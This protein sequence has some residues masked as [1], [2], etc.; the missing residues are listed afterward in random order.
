MEKYNAYTFHSDNIEDKKEKQII[1]INNSSPF[2]LRLVDVVVKHLQENNEELYE[3]LKNV[4]LSVGY[5]ENK[6]LQMGMILE[7][8]FLGKPEQSLN[9]LQEI[10]KL[11]TKE[12]NKISLEKLFELISYR[13]INKLCTENKDNILQH[14]LGNICTISRIKLKSPPLMR[15]INYLTEDLKGFEKKHGKKIVKIRPIKEEELILNYQFKSKIWKIKK[16]N[17]LREGYAMVYPDCNDNNAI[18]IMDHRINFYVFESRENQFLKHGFIPEIIPL[19]RQPPELEKAQRNDLFFIALLVRVLNECQKN[20]EIK[21]VFVPLLQS[22]NNKVLINYH[23]F[24]IEK[25]TRKEA[26]APFTINNRKYVRLARNPENKSFFTLYPS[27]NDFEVINERELKFLDLNNQL[28]ILRN[29]PRPGRYCGNDK[30][31][32]SRGYGPMG[33][34]FTLPDEKDKFCDNHKNWPFYKVANE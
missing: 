13:F 18:L 29:E 23:N 14:N 6:I 33:R 26:S 30:F 8:Y 17:I 25:R 22:T 32:R 3:K 12:G 5:V 10:N 11:L 28:Q 31:Y 4:A 9:L 27:N 1:N 19:Y 7:K 20:E 2:L 21:Y 24:L 34:K 16:K 15:M